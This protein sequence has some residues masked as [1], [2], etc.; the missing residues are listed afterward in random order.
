M[1]IAYGA[2]AAGTSQMKSKMAPEC[3]DMINPMG[4][5]TV[6]NCTNTLQQGVKGLG[7]SSSCEC[8]LTLVQCVPRG[9]YYLQKNVP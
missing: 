1:F 9:K 2:I 5:K 8:I 6:K 7:G 4:C 3:G